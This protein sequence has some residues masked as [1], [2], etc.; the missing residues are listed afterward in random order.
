[1]DATEDYCAICLCRKHRIVSTPCKHTFC[2]RCL[3]KVYDVCPTKVCPL[4][5]APFEYYIRERGSGIKIVFL[6]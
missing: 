2:K 4:C 3:K 6:A 1:M 5:R